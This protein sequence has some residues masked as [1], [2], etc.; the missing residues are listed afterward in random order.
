MERTTSERVNGAAAGRRLRV[1][2]YIENELLRLGLQALLPGLGSVA[3]AV[4]CKESAELAALLAE[5]RCDVAL[6]SSSNRSL[7]AG[8]A[9]PGGPPAF[10]LLVLLDR[11]DPDTEDIPSTFPADGYLLREDLTAASLDQALRQLAGGQ[12]AIPLR[13]GRQL[14]A[15]AAAPARPDTPRRAAKLTAREGE[16]L[17]HLVDG[18]SNK[19]IARRLGISEHG[20]KRLVSSVLMKLDA[21]SRTAAAVTAVQTGLVNR[22]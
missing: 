22:G 14:L 3:A 11:W 4:V 19:Q 12:M 20:A 18:L 7:P 13:L 9:V 10:R 17:G 8:C 21:T 15:G 2:V 5:E 16:T 6:V 1:A